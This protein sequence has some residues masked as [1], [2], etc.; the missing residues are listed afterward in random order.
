MAHESTSLLVN[1]SST[2]LQY[3]LLVKDPLGEGQSNKCVSFHNI[4]YEVSQQSCFKKLPPKTILDNI[5][6]IMKTG[7]NAIMGPT[8]SGKTTLLDILA[9]HKDR[10]GLSGVVLI[11]GENQPV[12]FKC[13]SAYVVQD[14]IIMGTLSVRENIAFSAALRLPS[15]YTRTDRK[16]RVRQ[17]IEELGLTEVAD[18][19]VGTEFIRGISGGEKKRT[20]IGMEL[21]IA[22]GILFL[23]EPTTGLDA[24]TAI[25]V[26]RL[27]KDLSKQDRVIIISIH[28]PRYSIYKLFDSLTL[29]SKGNMVYYG[30]AGDHALQYFSDNG[31]ECEQHNN[32]ADFFLDVVISCEA[33][34]MKSVMYS[35]SESAG[36]NKLSVAYTQSSQCHKVTKEL[37]AILEKAPREA[38]KVSQFASSFPWQLGVLAVRAVRNLVRNPIVSIV[39]ML[40]MLILST[41]VGIIYFQLKDNFA[42][43]QNRVGAF[44]F[45]ITNVVFGSF[46][47]IEL[48]IRERP[49]FIHQSARGYYRVS[50]FFFTKVFC[51]LLPMRIVPVILYSA[52][53]YWMLGL[54][55]ELLHFAIYSLTLLLASSAAS[56]TA[57]LVSAG[58]RVLALATM[59]VAMTFIFQMIFGGFLV[60]LNTVVVWLSWI[61]YISIFRFSLNALF[62]NELKGSYYCNRIPYDFANRTIYECDVNRTVIGDIYL[63]HWGTFVT[64]FGTMRWGCSCMLLLYSHLH[65]SP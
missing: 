30:I 6:G 48:F 46:S 10:K 54:K 7:L 40:V 15:V 34:E 29:L 51:D 2:A 41:I 5:S 14:D 49:L 11:N 59:L 58:V 63:T 47:A 56:A 57:F 64:I 45:I 60:N 1:K 27:L 22:P 65:T 25:S 21:I 55:K 39:Q 32:P 26:I 62:E 18:S 42:G 13:K 17:V 52:I 16:E 19:K 24:S 3:G 61:Q 44:Y 38:K 28:Q 33:Q 43:F 37:A 23:D 50:A 31:Y 20:S 8:G 35:L 36:Q 53:S 9:G 4:S 12:N